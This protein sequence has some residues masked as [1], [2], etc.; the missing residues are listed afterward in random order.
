MINNDNRYKYF[1]YLIKNHIMAFRDFVQEHKTILGII[2]IIIVIFIIYKYFWKDRR[3]TKNLNLQ[4]I[5]N[6]LNSLE[7]Q[8]NYMASNNRAFVPQ[9]QS[10]PQLQHQP[11]YQQSSSSPLLQHNQYQMVPQSNPK[12]P[13]LFQHPM[14]SKIK[15]SDA[16][17]KSN[18]SDKCDD[19]SVPNM[20]NANAIESFECTKCK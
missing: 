4:R 19:C 10:Q 11:Q 13:Q 1:F 5:E 6:K 12:H 14:M 3:M 2:L 18:K 8:V 9:Y 16:S 20:Y 15:I 17:D 7:Q